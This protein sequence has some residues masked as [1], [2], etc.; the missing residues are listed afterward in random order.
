MM[1]KITISLF[2]LFSSLY[3]FTQNVIHKISNTEA[4]I[5]AKSICYNEEFDYYIC[6]NVYTNPIV[7]GIVR[8]GEYILVCVD[9]LPL[10]GWNHPCKYIYIQNLENAQRNIYCQ[11]A[12]EPPTDNNSIILG[13]SRHPTGNKEFKVDFPKKKQPSLVSSPQQRGNTFAVILN[14]GKDPYK[15]NE[16]YW[17][18][19]SF[20]Y[21]TL[22]NVYNIPKNNI[23]VIMSDGT[24]PSL[25]LKLYGADSILVSS[26]LDLDDDGKADIEY[27]A[28][29]D[30]LRKVLSDLA[31]EVTDN[32]HLLFFVVD[33]GGRDETTLAS[34]ICLWG[35]NVR[36]YPQEL[37][38]MLK[39]INVGYMTFV[40]GQCYSGGFIKDL[41]GDNRLIMTACRENELSYCRPVEPFDEFVYQL[42]SALA[43]CTPYGES[44]DADYD[45]DGMV[46]LLEAYRYAEEN[47]GYNDG[48]FSFGGVREHPQVSYLA[49]SNAEDLSLSCVPSPV[50]LAFADDTPR[51]SGVSWDTEAIILGHGTEVADWTN[52]NSEFSEGSSKKVSVK[53]RN[54]GVK[55]YASGDKSI[56][57]GWSAASYN[58]ADSAYNCAGGLFGEKMLQETL[59]PG[60]GKTISFEKEF[61]SD[62][63]QC[64][65]ENGFGMNYCAKIHSPDGENGEKTCARKQVQSLSYGNGRKVKLENG[66]K[67]LRRY[68]IHFSTKNEKGE[69]LVEAAE[70]SFRSS[71]I[72]AGKRTL[73]GMTENPYCSDALLIEEDKA[74][75]SGITM[76]SGEI[77][78]TGLECSFF[79]GTTVCDTT[80]YAVDVTVADEGTGELVGA[81]RFV[82]RRLPRSAI[83]VTPERYIY[84]GKQYLALTDSSEPVSCRWFSPDGSYIGDGL[85]CALGEEPVLGEYK[86]RAQSAE[87]GAVVYKAFS[88]AGDG[89]QKRVNLDKA[90]SR[91]TVTFR[92]PLQDDVDVIV[93][94]ASSKGQTTRLSKGQRVYNVRYSSTGALNG[95][96]MV[97]FIVNGVK[98]ETYKLQ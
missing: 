53:I 9:M 18:D 11:D 72:S 24:D 90:S 43:G 49:G 12:E 78:V 33:H 44:V 75:I 28:T 64:V 61:S 73:L 16:N 55:P 5:I 10:A 58:F 57:L 95:M 39:D 69:D 89:L 19:C 92:N 14:G 98:T 22:R 8:K 29:K 97:T 66:S 68:A 70:L 67:E 74:E 1:Y 41:Q 80:E 76:Q 23:K 15:N 38:D 25:D 37:A 79:A 4:M 26:P 54:R 45:K 86:L 96:L 27:A 71:G 82:A 36:L 51:Q 83:N 60:Q 32:D 34:Y 17:Y 87:D 88:V 59:L 65:K 31:D 6:E 48:D 62:E 47:D 42:T 91:I 35:D 94:T 20:L 93:S 77:H 85:S 7:N 81:E 50:E 56:A 63:I 2:L 46:T 84:N 30:N 13:N 21:T 3:G 40:L 52:T